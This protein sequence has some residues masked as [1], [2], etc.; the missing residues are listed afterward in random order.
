MDQNRIDWAAFVQTAPEVVTT[1]RTL[2]KVIADSGLEKPLLELLK[3]RASQLNGCAFCLALHVDFARKA[4]ITQHAVD[5][6]ATWREA[7]IFSAR[8]QAALAWTEALTLM[9]QQHPSDGD[10]EA[11][12]RQFSRQEIA[13]LTSSIALINAWNRIAGGLRF[14]PAAVS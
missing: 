6:V 9:A 7:G 8:E 5:L 2:T 12:C 14:A 1:L 10:Y 3:V 11:V 4:G 13:F